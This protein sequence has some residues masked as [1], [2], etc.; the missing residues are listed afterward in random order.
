[1]V[2]ICPSGSLTQLPVLQ[3]DPG[4]CGEQAGLAAWGASHLGISPQRVEELLRCLVAL[5]SSPL[6][7]AGSNL[8]EGPAFSLGDF[9]VGKD[10]EQNQEHGEDDEHIGTAQL[11]ERDRHVSSWYDPTARL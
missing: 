11:L 4:G 9:E 2:E 5:A 8:V 1:M 6:S 7:E 3:G 10:E